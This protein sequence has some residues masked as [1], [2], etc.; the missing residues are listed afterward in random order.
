[1]N[2]PN[3]SAQAPE[4]WKCGNEFLP[5]HPQASHVPPDYRDG[6]NGCWRDALAHYLPAGSAQAPQQLQGERE[7]FEKWY[8]SK[9]GTGIALERIG[10]EYLFADV[11]CSWT[12]WQARA[13]LQA[14]PQVPTRTIWI[15][16]YGPVSL[17]LG[18]PSRVTCLEAFDTEAEARESA[19]KCE[20]AHAIFPIATPPEAARRAGLEFTNPGF[21]FGARMTAKLRESDPLN[22]DEAAL[23][24]SPE[25]SESLGVPA[26]PSGSTL[27]PAVYAAIPNA[28]ADVLRRCVRGIDHLSEVARQWEPDHSSGAD[29]RGWLLAKDAADDARELLARG[30]VTRQGGDAGAAPSPKAIA[31]GPQDAPKSG[32]EV[33]EDVVQRLMEKVV[34]YGLEQWLVGGLPGASMDEKYAEV[35]SAIRL[36]LQ[37]ADQGE[38]SLS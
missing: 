11:S 4:Q 34:D 14:A 6:W 21:F 37:G 10:K 23:Q 18:D 29:R 31:P 19:T 13:G 2:K 24:P 8:R 28:V 33:R 17:P 22:W 7:A 32:A 27:Q 12:A 25:P 36:A 26:A 35:E 16:E 30:G 1:V 5:F 9:C 3:E 38:Q 15:L 20:Y